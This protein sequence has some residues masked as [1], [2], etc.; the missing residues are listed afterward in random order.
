MNK[1]NMSLI[2]NGAKHCLLLFGPKR[3]NWGVKKV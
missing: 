1:A 2:G 3:L